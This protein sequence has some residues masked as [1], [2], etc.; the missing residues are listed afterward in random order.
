M[1]HQTRPSWHSH[2]P[3]LSP[4]SSHPLRGPTSVRF[5]IKADPRASVW[6]ADFLRAASLA[7]LCFSASSPSQ[8]HLLSNMAPS[9]SPG[10]PAAGWFQNGRKNHGAK[11]Q[12]LA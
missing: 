5:Y 3:P 1:P 9:R 6:G 11:K 4:L 2:I 10:L 7:R 8:L 12:V